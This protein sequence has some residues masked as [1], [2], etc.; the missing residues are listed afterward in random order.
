MWVWQQGAQGH[1]DH[2]RQSGQPRH[3][4][5]WEAVRA[6]VGLPFQWVASLSI[7][8]RVEDRPIGQ[9]SSRIGRRSRAC[10]DRA[11]IWIHRQ[12]S[13]RFCQGSVK[14]T[15]AMACFAVPAR[16]CPRDVVFWV[17]ILGYQHL[18]WECAC[19]ATLRRARHSREEV[20]REN[21]VRPVIACR[22]RPRVELTL[23]CRW[24]RPVPVCVWMATAVVIPRL[25]AASAIIHL[26]C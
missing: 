6:S 14:C 22:E 23:L 8:R 25:G 2:G 15:L 9:I 5:A 11:F 3:G 24:P 13:G 10:F 20:H 7:D 17:D 16:P 21:D 19:P 12:R 4:E 18:W 1:D 26:G